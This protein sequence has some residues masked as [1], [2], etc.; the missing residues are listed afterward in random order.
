MKPMLWMIVLII[1]LVGCN[2]KAERRIHNYVERYN[3][4]TSGYE[5]PVFSSPICS[6]E[7]GSRVCIE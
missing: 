2:P 1:L 6:K 5:V 7:P 4:D 3:L